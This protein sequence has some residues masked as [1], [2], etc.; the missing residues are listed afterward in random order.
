M[1]SG[2]VSGLASLPALKMVTVSLCLHYAQRKLSGVSSFSYKDTGSIGSGL[3]LITSF[4]HNLL[5]GPISK[6]SHVGS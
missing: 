4:N 3:T 2:L 6:H 5:K 1:P